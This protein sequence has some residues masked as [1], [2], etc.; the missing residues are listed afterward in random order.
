[1]SSDQNEPLLMRAIAL[2]MPPEQEPH[3]IGMRRPNA[4]NWRTARTSPLDVTLGTA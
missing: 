3:E 4:L 1:M 2:T